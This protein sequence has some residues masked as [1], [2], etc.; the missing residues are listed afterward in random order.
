MRGIGPILIQFDVR[1][2]Q[3]AQRALGRIG[4]LRQE[5]GKQSER[6]PTPEAWA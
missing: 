3:M 2:V 4:Q 5:L 1:T 6:T